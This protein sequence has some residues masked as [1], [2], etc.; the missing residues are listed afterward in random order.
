M[1]SELDLK[2]KGMLVLSTD[3]GRTRI[4][5]RVEC[6]GNSKLSHQMELSGHRQAG[7]GMGKVLHKCRVGK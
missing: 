5:Q 4:T 7:K 6:S 3:E 1:R 2:G